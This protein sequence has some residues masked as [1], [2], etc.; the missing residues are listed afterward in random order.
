MKK[1]LQHFFSRCFYPQICQPRAFVSVVLLSVFFVGGQL[2]A[3][4]TQAQQRRPASEAAALQKQ[5]TDAA[6]HGKTNKLEQLLRQGVSPDT[7][8]AA[9]STLLIHAVRENYP[10]VV[11]V[12]LRY[13]PKLNLRNKNG[14]SA[15][16][17]AAFA[18]NEEIVDVLLKAGANVNPKAD[19]YKPLHYAAFQGHPGVLNQLLSAG[20]DVNAV[21]KNKSD[22]LM[23]A[24]RNG[25]IEIVKRLLQ[26]NI[27]LDH[28]N[29]NGVTAEEWAR[30]QKN[31]KIADLIAK[32]RKGRR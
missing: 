19:S 20:A 12:I 23:L 28:R 16:K 32:A 2:L 10:K 14:D 29:E 3:D 22:A 31:T 21:T 25:H 15:L 4:T 5:A 13:K 30:K 24:A 17:L 8:D 26:T 9:G 1:T 18:G 11:S 7:A 6:K 27:N